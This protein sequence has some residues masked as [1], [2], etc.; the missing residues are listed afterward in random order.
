M[1]CRHST[2]GHRAGP[3]AALLLCLHVLL[4]D[5]QLNEMR[6]MIKVLQEDCKS[7]AGA[8]TQMTAGAE[9]SSV[10]QTLPPNLVQASKQVVA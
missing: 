9:L 1:L 6:T 4:Q 8:L 10:L 3:Y 2:G 7:L 5:Q